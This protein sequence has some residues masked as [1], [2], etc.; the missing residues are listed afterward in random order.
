MQKFAYR[1]LGPAQAPLVHGRHLATMSAEDTTLE[2]H[3]NF[4]SSWPSW[5]IGLVGA[6]HHGQ[7][8]LDALP[9]STSP[10][11]TFPFESTFMAS[12]QWSWP[13]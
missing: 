2:G 13:A 6:G 4:G 1:G 7:E 5:L 8:L 9:S 12:I 3:E 10:L 11:C